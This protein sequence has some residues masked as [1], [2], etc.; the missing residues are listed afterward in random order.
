LN[1]EHGAGLDRFTIEVD[2]T[3]AALAGVATQM[4][5]GQGKLIAQKISKQCSLFDINFPLHTIDCQ[6][7]FHSNYT[8]IDN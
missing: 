4:G 8:P 6:T 5:A 3:T 7:N 2:R 1:G